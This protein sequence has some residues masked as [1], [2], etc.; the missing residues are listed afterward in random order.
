MP[1]EKSGKNLQ[2]IAWS[3]YIRSLLHGVICI[4]KCQ[5]VSKYFPHI[6]SPDQFLVNDWDMVTEK[7]AISMI[8]MKLHTCTYG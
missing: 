3:L 4:T 2:I 6:L 7:L 1:K 8:P 5:P